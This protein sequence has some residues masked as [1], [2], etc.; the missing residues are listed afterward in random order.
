MALDETAGWDALLVEIL[1]FGE[2]G[3]FPRRGDPYLVTA[4]NAPA[5][6]HRSGVGA[7]EFIDWLKAARAATLVLGEQQV[8]GHSTVVDEV[9][10]ILALGPAETR[11][12]VDLVINFAEVAVLPFEAA[13]DRDGRPLLVGQDPPTVLTRRIR[14]PFRE[15]TPAWPPKPHAL[16]VA[17]SPT[18]PIP[19]EEHKQAMRTALRPWIE[20]LGDFAEPVPHEELLLTKLDRAS[21]GEIRDACAQ[22][23]PPFTH[24]HVLAH[25]T[26]IGDGFEQRFGLELFSDDKTAAV[27]VTGDDLADAL[28]AGAALPT[29][30]T[31]T[32]CDSGNVGSPVVTGASAAHALHA[33]GVPVVVASQFPMT[34]AGSALTVETFYGR[35]LAGEDVR[36]ALLAT[37]TALYDA[38]D[39]AGEDWISLVAYVQLPEGYQDRLLDVRLAA[40]FASLET[41]QRW[42]DH[43]VEH[44]AV[45]ARYELVAARLLERLGS[46]AISEQRSVRR[47]RR[48]LVEESRG[49][50]GSA[51]KRLA[52]LYFRRSALEE[53]PAPTL[54]LSKRALE[55]SA[56][57]Y[58]RAFADDSAAHWVGVQELSLE[59]VVH[60]HILE[61]WRWNAAL[62]ATRREQA[63]QTDAMW[64]L[65]SRAELHLLA[66]Y[67]G[68]RKQLDEAA[69]ALAEF[70]EL[71][72]PGDPRPIDSTARQLKRYMDWWTTDNGFFPGQADLRVEASELLRNYLA[73]L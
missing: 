64:Q 7:Q 29:V 4:G 13:K 32:A 2:E 41:A 16:L 38:R 12:Q 68:Q 39:E 25:G 31:L 5:R 59:A 42:A 72:P 61:P 65:G 34:F 10:R 48:D 27:A 28:C 57:W 56:H 36:D 50:L 33:R 71:V 60:G 11:R 3:G 70:A 73:T 63:K 66:P 20:P 53:D 21:L 15:R 47:G 40:D 54:E 24:V 18:L 9:S 22:A 69:A 30:V 43:L 62:A 26:A 49:L 51:N 17:S 45:P 58:A 37:R 1:R 6:E 8:D 55:E 44:G 14:R 23:K 46:L 19:L 52:E 35:L 67:A